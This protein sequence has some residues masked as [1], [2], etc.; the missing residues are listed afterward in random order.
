MVL[1]LVAV[2]TETT[3]VGWYDEAFMISTADSDASEVWDK[4]IMS[5]IGRAH[6]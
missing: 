6:V 1:D 5:K 3:G 2:D 4:R